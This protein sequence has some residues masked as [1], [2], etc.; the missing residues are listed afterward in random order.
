MYQRKNLSQSPNP[1]NIASKQEQID[2]KV[3]KSILW[4][5][6]ILHW[7]LDANQKEMYDKFLS[8]SNRIQTI[9]CSRQ[10]GK[11]FMMTVLAIETCLKKPNTYVKF[12]AP[13]VKMI[14]NILIPL[15]NEVTNDC[16]ESLKPKHDVAGNKFKF[17]NGSEIQMAGTD[18]N[19]ADSIRGTKAHLCIVDEAAF[20]DNLSYII[21]SILLPTTTTTKGRIILVST[22][23]K[24]NDHDFVKYWDKAEWDGTLIFRTIYDNPR[25]TE[26]D[27]NDLAEAI[28]GKHT[29]DFQREYLCKKIVSADDAVIPEF[30]SELEERIVVPWTRPTHYDCYAS[31]D[32]GFSDFTVV[33]FAYYDFKQAKLIIE[34][35]YVINGR[36]LTTE[37][38]ADEVKSKE[39]TLWFNRITGDY[40]IPHIRVS[41]NNN[42]ILLND[43]HQKYGLLFLPTAKDNRD[44]AINNMKI[45]LKSEKIIINPRCIT[46]INH[47]RNAIWN[48]ART[49]F[50]R[51]KDQGHHYDAI[52]ALY[53]LCRNVNFNK[54]PYPSG[55]D[56]GKGDSLFHNNNQSINNPLSDMFKIR[57]PRR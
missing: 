40:K 54:N 14:K 46:L 6:G 5:K 44:A 36:K 43:L 38:L 17:N 32:V 24:T 7:K 29:S 23:P 48:K 53:Y 19:N 16:P 3:A 2:A 47:L 37:T 33:L 1:N 49:D 15:V 21:K 8:G 52:P 57:K 30:T 35:E 9:L 31:M 20:A 10:L 25:L 22:P 55:Y 18:N 34:D 41:D 11:S 12:I 39:K 56:L 28:G 50:V 4:K 13:E 27:I 26:T 42:L 51:N 45:L